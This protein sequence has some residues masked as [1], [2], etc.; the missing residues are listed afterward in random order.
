MHCRALDVT[1]DDTNAERRSSE[2]LFAEHH[3]LV[4][5]GEAA[6]V[7]RDDGDVEQR[8]ASAAHMIDEF[9]ELPYLA[10]APMEPN[11]A[12]CRMQPDGMLEVWASTESPEYTRH[13]RGNRR[14]H[15]T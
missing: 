2:E 5:S 12:V 13:G 6:V 14:R 8:L 9:Y 10:H 15:R 11:N 1:W 4:E 3:R 7:V